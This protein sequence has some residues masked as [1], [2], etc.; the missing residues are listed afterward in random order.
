M[1]DLVERLR[2]LGTEWAK[3]TGEHGPGVASLQR[4]A[5]AEIARLQEAKRAALKVADERSKE[6]VELRKA[7]GDLIDAYNNDV[8]PNDRNETAINHACRVLQ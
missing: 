1:D 3:A 4:E 6:N 8:N 5:A 7:L 2:T